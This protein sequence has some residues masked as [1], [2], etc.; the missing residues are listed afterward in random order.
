MLCTLYCPGAWRSFE[1]WPIIVSPK[2]C[3]HGQFRV[4]NRMPMRQHAFKC[5]VR[6][7]VRGLGDLLRI[8]RLLYHRNIACMANS[9]C[10]AGCRCANTHLNAMYA[11]L[12]V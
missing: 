2:Y 5:Y 1:N 9:E 3:L 7:T 11:L 4:S 6:F 8:G 10:R 12:S